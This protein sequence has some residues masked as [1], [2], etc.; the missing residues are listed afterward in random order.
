M[1]FAAG[2][3]TAPDAARALEEAAGL[4]LERL[5][6][7]PDLAILFFS[8]HH[9]SAASRLAGDASSRLGTRCL[10][11]CCGE[12]IVANDREIERQPALNV[13]LGRWD[14]P[15]DLQLFNLYIEETAD[16]HSLLGWPDE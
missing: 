16:G 6:G 9:L 12:A 8:P 11:G 4:A 15:V 3:S 13:W 10:L 5:Q 2:L 7:T 14:Q 1:P